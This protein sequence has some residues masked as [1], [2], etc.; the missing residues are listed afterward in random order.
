MKKFIITTICVA[1]LPATTMAH[2][3]HAEFAVPMGHDIAH[4]MIGAGLASAAI[5]AGIMVRKGVAD[6][7]EG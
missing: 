1:G 5:V 2:P 3:G 4:L 7:R 6:R